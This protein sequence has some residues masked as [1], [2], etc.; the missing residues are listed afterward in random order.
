MHF[1]RTLGFDSNELFLHKS[2]H[3]QHDKTVARRY[4]WKKSIKSVVYAI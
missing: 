2:G 3:Q 1:Y 4:N